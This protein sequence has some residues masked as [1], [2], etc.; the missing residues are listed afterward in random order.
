V[1]EPNPVPPPRIVLAFS[2]GL[3]TSFLVPWLAERHG[4]EV[5]TVTVDTGGLDETARRSLGE[6]SRALGAAG[7]LLIEAARPSSTRPCGS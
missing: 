2:G 3:D 5:V 7:H 1:A 6:R 4:A